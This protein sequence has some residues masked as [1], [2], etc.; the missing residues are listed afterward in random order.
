[1][2]LGMLLPPAYDERKWTLARQIGVRHAITLASPE[3]SG[4]PAPDDWAALKSIHQ[5]FAEAGFELIGLEGDQFD[6]SAIK[7]G[8]PERDEYIERYCRMLENMDKLDIRLLCYNFMAGI[9]WYRTRTDVQERGGALVTAFDN[10]EAE[11][12]AVD[13][14]QKITEE[15]LWDNLFYFLDAVL[16]VAQEHGVSLSLHPDDPP[17]SPLKGIGRILTTSESFEKVW[18]RHPVTSN[19]ITFCQAT[20][21]TM[22]ED[23]FTLSE[24]WLKEKRIDFL[25]LRDV[26]G[27]K[28]RFR[29]TFH[30]NGPTPMASLLNHYAAHGFDGPLRPDHAPLMYGEQQQQFAGGISVGYEVTGKIFAIG[31]IKGIC[32]MAGI[33]SE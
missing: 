15:K 26:A 1:M 23:L 27:D 28:Y 14:A 29:E 2:K 8:L 32:D 9:G 7:Q 22:D 4:K 10:D 21:K 24:R 17:L 30:D 31:Y 11:K 18:Q 12:E 5:E 13:E 6:M 20:F 19:R 33:S 3:L 25:H 16:P